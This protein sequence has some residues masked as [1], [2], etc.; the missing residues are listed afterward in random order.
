MALAVTMFHLTCRRQPLL[1]CLPATD[2][3]RWPLQPLTRQVCCFQPLL[4]PPA[5]S[6]N[7]CI[8]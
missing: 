2:P 5:A 3:L 7:Q 8:K 4:H 1:L 6:C